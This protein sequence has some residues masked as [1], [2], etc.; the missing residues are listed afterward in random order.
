MPS[1]RPLRVLRHALEAGDL[2]L[3]V[4]LA[5]RLDPCADAA[6]CALPRLRVRPRDHVLL[7]LALDVL[8]SGS[9]A[10]VRLGSA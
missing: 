8:A 3:A 4:L 1:D 2:A 6:L 9:T 10:P 7:S 5:R